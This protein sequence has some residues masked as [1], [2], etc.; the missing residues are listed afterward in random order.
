[1]TSFVQGA[2]LNYRMFS[3]LQIISYFLSSAQTL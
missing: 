1:L 3:L 2:V